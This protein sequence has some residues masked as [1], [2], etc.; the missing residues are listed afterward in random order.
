[1][2][3]KTIGF[4]SQLK[5]K[6][7]DSTFLKDIKTEDLVN[8]G[9][10]SEFIGRLPV[11]SIFERLNEND[12]FKILKSPNNPVILSKKLDFA[13]YGI[14]VKFEDAALKI[15]AD[16][17]YKENTGARGLVSSVEQALLSFENKLP[18][19]D[20][21]ITY[22]LL[23]G[24]LEKAIEREIAGIK[25]IHKDASPELTTRLKHMILS[26]DGKDDKKDIRDFVDNYMLARDSRA[27]RDYI[28]DT[29]PD[30][31]LSYILDNGKEV[32][33]PIG[34]SFFWPDA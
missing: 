23:T 19:S 32:V 34:L 10:E 16:R 3:K 2:S 13:A 33:I 30:V 1:M 12:L 8:F 11:R 15:L 21:T 18:S 27:F 5:N 25:K 9:F 28:K 26:V 17:A 6:E 22:Q 14:D 20:V 24:K 7:E 29:Q 31:N 4:G